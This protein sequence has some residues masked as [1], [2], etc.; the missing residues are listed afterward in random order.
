[1]RTVTNNVSNV[2]IKNSKFICFVYNVSSIDEVN[3]YLNDIRN[4]YKDASHCCY[5]YVIDNVKK[6]SDDGEPG[7]TAGV[8]IMQVLESNDLNY[9][10]CVVV[11]YFGGIKLGAG[12]LVRAYSKSVSQCLLDHIKELTYGFNVSIIFDY[13]LN[14][15][16]D[17]I[18]RDIKI[19]SKDFND[20]VSYTLNCT[21]DIITELKSIGVNVIV[22][23]DLYY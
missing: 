8:P 9:V 22:N 23:N 6:S 14:K 7:G 18:L 10:L 3:I 1:M 5:A 13:S 4:Q 12:G 2:V 15:K 17:Y 16:V 11:R 20:T 21:E 19:I